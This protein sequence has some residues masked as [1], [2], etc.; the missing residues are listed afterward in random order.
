MSSSSS[1][2]VD[3]KMEFVL[4]YQVGSYKEIRYPDVRV[5]SSRCL[6]YLHTAIN[7]LTYE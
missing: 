7:P 6:V 2:S 1:Y 4:F 3:V 5:F